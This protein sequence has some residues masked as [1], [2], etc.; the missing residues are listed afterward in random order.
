MPEHTH[1]RITDLQIGSRQWWIEQPRRTWEFWLA[2][3]VDHYQG[4][5]ITR[6]IALFFAGMVGVSIVMQHGEIGANTLWLGLAA[7]S[8]AFG[9]ST[10]TFLLSKAQLASATVQQTVTTVSRET[11]EHIRATRDTAT[12][13]PG[14]FAP[15]QEPPAGTTTPAAPAAAAK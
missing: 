6:V 13:E 4:I 12:G 9:K 10:F 15:G 2:P 3:L 5:S 11:V 14:P 1:H 7:I 8:A